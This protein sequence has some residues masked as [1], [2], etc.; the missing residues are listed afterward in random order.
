MITLFSST[1][2]FRF[3]LIV[4]KM[5]LRAQVTEQVL[6][7]Q[8]NTM[9]SKLWTRT[10]FN[11]I[12]FL[13]EEVEV[14]EGSSPWPQSALETLHTDCVQGGKS[15]K[16]RVLFCCCLQD[17]TNEP[18]RK[19]GSGSDIRELWWAFSEFYLLVAVHSSFIQTITYHVQ[20][21]FCF[22]PFGIISPLILKLYTNHVWIICLCSLVSN[23]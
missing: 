20:C 21:P 11:S 2:T 3:F 19:A 12:S 6:L 14:V 4:L 13:G 10:R 7:S 5:K 9:L 8:L 22:S 18:I 1:S 15:V 23:L 17:H 16:A